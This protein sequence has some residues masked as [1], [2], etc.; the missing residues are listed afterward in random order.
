M[1]IFLSFLQ[2]KS[3]HPVPAY[4][5]WEYYIKNGIAEAGYE[6]AEC[7]EV[8]WAEGLVY[9]NGGELLDS[10]KAYS[11]DKTI[12][13]LK[14]NKVDLF[15]SYLYP[16]QVDEQ[17]IKQ[18]QALGIPC[19]NYFC[20]NVREFTSVPKSYQPFDLHWVPEY[21]ALSLYKKA[22][23]NFLNLPMPVWVKP[24]NRTLN[25][26]EKYIPT[27][28]GSIDIQRAAL[29]QNVLKK[30]PH[31]ALRGPGWLNEKKN[32]L[33]PVIPNTKLETFQNQ[34]AFISKN[35]LKSFF[36]KFYNQYQKPSVDFNFLKEF[37]AQKAFGEAYFEVTKNAIITIGVNRYPSFRQSVLHPDTYSRLRDIE[38]P[39]L[40]ACYLTEATKGLELLYDID[41]EIAVFSN[42]NDMIDQIKFLLNHPEQRKTLR[43]QGQKKALN[44]LGIPQSLKQ[45]VNSFN[46]KN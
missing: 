9:Q 11:W 30:Y 17:A 45:I 3:N 14:K 5:F 43:V 12:A 40:G 6:W 26:Q 10:W 31:I 28:V 21:K 22:G 29:F 32:K 7:N 20:D 38:A 35:G 19:V 16:Y 33:H 46:L 37:V 36:Y 41:K 34:I 42:E 44:E 23:L 24:E 8:D 27:F 18:I 1:K 2:G 39:M 13:Y 25:S 15:L 4:S